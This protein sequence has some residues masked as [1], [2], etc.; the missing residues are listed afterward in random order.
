MIDA[1]RT[2]L[3]ISVTLSLNY[4]SGILYNKT[5]IPDHV[6]LLSFGI[7]VGPIL[8]VFDSAI[9]MDILDLTLLVTVA[10]FMFNMGLKIHIP[11]LMDNFSSVFSLA[12][13]SFVV[14][15]LSVAVFLRLLLPGHFTLVT[16]LL[17][18][19]MVG[20]VDGVSTGRLFNILSLDAQTVDDSLDLESK[21]VDPIKMVGVLSIIKLI[22]LSG[23]PVSLA[24]RELLFMLTLSIL[25]G[26]SA[27][28]IWG[29]VLSRI[30]DRSLNYLLTIAM[31]FPVYVVSGGFTGGGPISV[32]LFAVVLMNYS[33]VTQFLNM[34]RKSRINHRK[35]REY[36]DELTFLMN[37]MF[38]LYMGYTM[39]LNPTFF[40]IGA[41]L[42][43]S[44]SGFRYVTVTLQGK[45]QDVPYGRFFFIQGASALFFSKFVTIYDPDAIFFRGSGMFTN[46]VVPIVYSSILLTS[47]MAFFF[48][49]K[50]GQP[51]VPEEETLDESG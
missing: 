29:E 40:A 9:F 39:N 3:L 25:I 37:A 21:L 4:L 35:I 22:S 19:A 48:A 46:L 10:L 5:K 16:G 33:T 43:I 49:R 1:E 7:L 26:V 11:R 12:L 47:L 42:T 17:L 24:V 41:L 34:N 44:T 32:F 6:W 20:G 15:S 30:R 36:L 13:A 18:G 27:G 31:I 38:F 2:L 28:L 14:T 45:L 8:N 23:G 51:I 50:E